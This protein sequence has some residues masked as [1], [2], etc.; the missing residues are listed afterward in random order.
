[1]AA[2]AAHSQ[3]AMLQP[4][5][6][7]IVLEFLLNIPR[8]IGLLRFEVL[9]EHTANLSVSFTVVDLASMGTD[10]K[11]LANRWLLTWAQ[12]LR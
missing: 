10:N 2:F 4:T 3:E 5:T 11:L 12:T 8:Q 1:M 7:E 6:L 9:F